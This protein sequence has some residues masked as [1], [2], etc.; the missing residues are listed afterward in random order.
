MARHI[1]LWLTGDEH[2]LLSVKH[3]EEVFRLVTEVKKEY[4]IVNTPTAF[5]KIFEMTRERIEEK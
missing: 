4:K 2:Y 3:Y 5:M 1:D